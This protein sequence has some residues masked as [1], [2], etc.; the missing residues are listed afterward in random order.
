MKT[1]IIG[2]A[3]PAK[4]QEYPYSTT[5]LYEWLEECGIS[6]DKAQEMFEFE[7][8]YNQF[9][10]FDPNGGHL[11]PSPEQMQKNWDEHLEEKVQMADKVILLGKLASKFFHSQPKTWSCNLEVLELIH[12]SRLNYNLYQRNK[13]SIINKLNTFL[14]G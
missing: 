6:K 10:G 9:P 1:L 2:Q 8:A 5:L 7:A 11:K 12:P 4:P 14:N 13:T 3:L